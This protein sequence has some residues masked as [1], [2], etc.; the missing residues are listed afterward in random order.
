[1]D[2]ADARYEL[3]QMGIGAKKVFST[4]CN[5]LACVTRLGNETWEVMTNGN[6]RE[7]LNSAL[8]TLGYV[9]PPQEYEVG[10]M[11]AEYQAETGCD[12]STALALCNCD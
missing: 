12:W 10:L 2:Y 1:M 4:S 11:V 7:D 6:C 8:F 5:A 9:A 3:L